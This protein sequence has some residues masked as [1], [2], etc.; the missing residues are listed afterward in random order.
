V[1]AVGTF[2]LFYLVFDAGEGFVGGFFGVE[3]FF[4]LGLEVFVEGVV[5]FFF[6][7]WGGGHGLGGC[8]VVGG[9]NKLD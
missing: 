2:K 9:R 6:F 8:Q 3:G 7:G 1:G 5:D 4:E